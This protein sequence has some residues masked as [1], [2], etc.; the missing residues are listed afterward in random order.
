MRIKSKAT[1]ISVGQ[2]DAS[3][4]DKYASSSVFSFLLAGVAASGV[5]ALIM[6]TDFV[7]EWIATAY[8]A[9]IVFVCFWQLFK[10]DFSKS[11]AMLVYLAVLQPA[12]RE[13]AVVLPY[14]ILEYIVPVWVLLAIESPLKEYKLSASA[15]FYSI[16]ILLELLSLI[17]VKTLAIGRGVF[18]PSFSLWLF[19]LLGSD[20]K[21]KRPALLQVFSAYLLGA[22]NLIVLIV[23]PI[24]AGDVQ[25]GHQS[26]FAASGEMGPVQISMLLAMG[27]IICMFLIDQGGHGQ[28]IFYLGLAALLFSVMLLSFSRNGLYL[29]I[30]GAVIYLVI[31]QPLSF[32]R[33]IS[34]I[35]TGI[36]VVLLFQQ[37]SLITKGAA[38]Q[39]YR[40]LNTTNRNRL[41]QYG[42]E[43]FLENPLFGVGTGN[44]HYVVSRA[45]YFGVTSGAHNE[46][47]RAAAEHG[48]FGVIAWSCFA[49]SALW[50]AF[51]GA[52][53][54]ARAMRLTFILVALAYMAVNGL[55][56]LVQP[57]TIFLAIAALWEE[58]SYRDR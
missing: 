56:L 4:L 7:G 35:A 16:Y 48:I 33:L 14:Q 21:L 42:W 27:V 24:L 26:S 13:Y 6:N 51:W 5:W 53:G 36:I 25:W 38:E 20:R 9:I 18:L 11:L 17:T 39:R 19:L 30:L 43:I 15:I 52:K 1:G 58:P 47:I 31:F 22:L 49:L 57:I 23:P 2:T 50:Y 8:F 46:F 10:K 12:F 34:I 32:S 37:V 55:K 41:V 40:N 44:Y 54:K 3:G 45:E 29:V 28:R